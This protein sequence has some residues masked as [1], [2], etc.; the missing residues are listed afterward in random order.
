M[1]LREWGWALRWECIW[2]LQRTYLYPDLIGL[3]MP[4]ISQ[5][6]ASPLTLPSGIWSSSGGGLSEIHG[7]WKPWS[8]CLGPVRKAISP[9][10]HWAEGRGTGVGV[11]RCLLST[12][13]SHGHLAA[14]LFDTGCYQS[15]PATSR[16]LKSNIKLWTSEMKGDTLLAQPGPLWKP[17]SWSDTLTVPRVGKGPVWGREDL[18]TWYCSNCAHGCLCKRFQCDGLRQH[19]G[20]TP[21][22]K[23][24]FLKCLEAPPRR[25][26]HLRRTSGWDPWN[27]LRGDHQLRDE[28]WFWE[29]TSLLE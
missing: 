25:L 12:A 16:I 10:P 20:R 24:G 9:S 13:G 6:G 5:W 14:S 28:C 2:V 29:E 17:G 26:Q 15:G 11:Y 7:S 18:T 23:W 4:P 22:S 27:V 21:L 8:S 3:R 1:S 19:A